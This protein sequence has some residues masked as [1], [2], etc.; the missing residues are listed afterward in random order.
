MWYIYILKN[1]VDESYY[2]GSTED[3]TLRVG[4]HNAG[5]TKSTE[6]KRPW[7][8]VY[9]EEYRSKKEALKR[10]RQIKCWKSRK[11]SYNTT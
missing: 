11:T 9:T 2:I 1:Q 3:V 6:G 5:W 4:C 7:D 10:E 8:V